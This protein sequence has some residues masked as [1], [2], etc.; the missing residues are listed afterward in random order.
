MSNDNVRTQVCYEELFD[1]F[2]TA[3]NEWLQATPE[4]R[5]LLLL[6]DWKV[7]KEDFPPCALVGPDL[8]EA[9]VIDTMKQVIKLLENLAGIFRQQLSSA[10][11]ALQQ[12]KAFIQQQTQDRTNTET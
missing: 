5:S 11:S 12:A 4:A 9:A 2:K 1:K 8:T 10:N 6:V 7:G 3:A